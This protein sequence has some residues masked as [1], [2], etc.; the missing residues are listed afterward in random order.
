MI[1]SAL[2]VAPQDENKDD[3]TWTVDKMRMNSYI[4]GALWIALGLLQTFSTWLQ[5]GRHHVPLRLPPCMVSAQPSPRNLCRPGL[6][7]HGVFVLG[8][9]RLQRGW[10]T[11]AQH[12]PPV[13]YLP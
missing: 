6:D 5:V 13:V 12:S 10:E 2:T 7:P 11:S 8:T 3:G 1:R 9:T 4:F